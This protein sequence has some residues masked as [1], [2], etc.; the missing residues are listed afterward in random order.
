MS[1]A[2]SCR[3]PALKRSEAGRVVRLAD[4][5]M[6]AL[7]PCLLL[8][9]A[10]PTYAQKSSGQITGE[11]VDQNGAALPNTKVTV[12]QVETNLTRDVNTNQD[13]IYSVPDLPIGTYRVSATHGG[14]KE[15]VVEGVTVNVSTTTR[16]DFTMQ[17]GEVGERVDI[18]AESVQIQQETGTLSDVVTGE[19]VRE[20][21]LNGRSFVQLTQ[22]QPGVSPANNF[23][24]KNKGLFSGVDFSV[25]GNTTQS[26]LF[27]IDGANNNDTGS[28]RTVLLY[29]SIE[30]I[31]E[32]TM[33]RNSFSP[34]YGQASGAIISIATRG[35]ENTFHGSLFYFG[36]ND[37]LNAADFFANRVGGTK[38][39]L[40]RNDF[41]GSI[42]GPIVKDRLFFFYSQEFNKEIRGQTR[43]GSVPTLAERNGDFSQPRFAPDGTRCSGPAIGN[44][45]P[46]SANQI[47]PQADISPAGLAIT[48]IFPEPNIASP[49]DCN[50]WRQSTNSPI[51]FR[52][53][54]IRIDYK[55]TESNRIFGRYTQ[56]HWEN[57]APIL[58]SA[59]LWGDDAFPG[60]ESSWQQPSRQAAFKLSSTLGNSAV[61]E[62]QFSYSANRINITPE[63]GG[64]INE[65]LSTAVPGFF[66][67]SVKLNEGRRAHPT[68][69]GGIAPFS[70]N[71]GS[72]LWTAAPWKNALDI[73]SIR[74]DFSKVTGNHTFKLGFLHDWA[75]KDEDS[76]GA[77]ASESPQFWGACCANNSGNYLADI[78]TR[79]SRFGFAETSTQPVALTRYRNF[80][81]YFGD[82]WK[83]RSNLTLELGARYSYFP[84]PFDAED[85]MTS[86]DLRFYD[87]S[88]PASDFCNGIVVVPG[89]NPC[90]AFPGVSTPTE[91]VNRAL[92]ENDKNAI[93]PRLGIA[94]D[95][96]GNGKT[97]IRAGVGQF[98]QR[99][100]VSI[101][102]GMVAN[103]P[104]ALSIGGE[105]TLDD[106]GANTFVISGPPGGAPSRA[107]NPEA[108]LPNAWQWNLTVDQELWKDAVLE[109]GYVGNRALHQLISFDANQVLPQNR[110]AAALCGG[111]AG[112][113]NNLRP[114]RN[115]GFI[116]GFERSGSANYHSLQAMFKTRLF[117]K[118]QIQAA[119][120][121]SH[122]IG[123]AAL[124]D[125]SGGASVNT[126]TDTYDGSIDYGN[127][128]INRPHIFVLNSVI[129]LPS[130]KGSNE[131]TR[132]ALGGWEFATIYTA[133]SG[134]SV[135]PRIANGSISN[136]QAGGLA[137][138][139][140]SQSNVRPNRVPGVPCT[141]DNGDPTQ[142]INPAAFTLVGTLIGSP[143][144]ASRGSCLGPGI[145]N[146]DMSFYKNFTPAWLRKPFGES[147]RVQ[148]RLE[149]FN[150]FNH[151]QFRA[152]SLQNNMFINTGGQPV[153]CGNAPCSATNRVV[154][155]FVTNGGF[156]RS[157]TTRGPRE[158]QY[159]L[160]LVF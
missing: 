121:W 61:N 11:V 46:G 35:G 153:V 124:D 58:F 99:E 9:L 120:T 64:D 14:F 62:I 102:L 45:R 73:Y 134:S 147:A 30:A 34:E 122:S 4:L 126:R 17:V 136:L 74:D 5:L 142:I 22:L 157:G 135:I 2:D 91:G 115:F 54:N 96:F 93:A 28:N 130:F 118:S 18:V 42:G 68:F 40:R 50:N 109:V 3:F 158:I 41:G 152:D 106:N 49:N 23:D 80:E 114:A 105:R 149:M 1:K 76:L 94:W 84:E 129:Y 160:K 146:V 95:P 104:F 36:R 77:A 113:V 123:D 71:F 7:V 39:K 133:S 87:P 16:Q 57:P 13:G 31:G 29:P 116:A 131:F 90:A 85:R 127:T 27:L 48:R 89:T 32:F 24:S 82:T 55:I 63:L 52:E 44:G 19:Q 119:Y 67:E 125:S 25:N 143:G 79:G 148:L 26:N 21:P 144:N 112:C 12:T 107:H 92:R 88:R 83:V 150:A 78:L 81:L 33:L 128:G 53:E 75:G 151:T 111:D 155:S 132:A 51:D 98:F 60:V 145:N 59:G 8:L 101:A 110:I 103:A 37:K 66:P 117:G 10:L 47:I 72:D 69:W 43:F 86:F 38:D 137:G 156:G 15:T 65:T 56:D 6:L 139:G 70:S 97:A 154:T 140:T 138:T 20:L 108:L 141:I 159:A 100:R